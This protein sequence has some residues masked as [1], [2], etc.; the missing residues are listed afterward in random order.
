M[1]RKGPI[2]QH[3][4]IC[5]AC[6]IVYPERNL[7]VGPPLVEAYRLGEEGQWL[8]PWLTNTQPGVQEKRT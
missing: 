5:S 7:F 2:P 3:D 6:Q 1:G 8:G 4:A